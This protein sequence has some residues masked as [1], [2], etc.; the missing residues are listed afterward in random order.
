MLFKVLTI[1]FFIWCI[2]TVNWKR[3]PEAREV[4]R[5]APWVE[6]RVTQSAIVPHV[7][8]LP[9]MPLEPKHAVFFRSGFFLKNRI[10]LSKKKNTCNFI[11]VCV[12][13]LCVNSVQMFNRTKAAFL[14]EQLILIN[15]R[16][17]ITKLQFLGR[18]AVTVFG[19]IWRK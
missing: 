13:L 1:T 8:A 9:T 3:G 18:D 5:K 10:N 17:W 15:N 16:F 2:Y 19:L 4:V 12:N 6:S 14:F 11:C 7:G